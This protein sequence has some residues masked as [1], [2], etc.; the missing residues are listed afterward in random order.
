MKSTETRYCRA[1]EI[2]DQLA[3]ALDA[4]RLARQIDRPIDQATREFEFLSRANVSHGQFLDIV[5]RFLRH[6]LAR[7]FPNG[8]QLS[9]SQARDEAV[10]VL[11][12]A[13]SSGGNYEAFLEAAEPSEEGLGNVLVRVA[14]LIKVRQRDAHVRWAVATHIDPGDWRMKCQMAAIL[15]ERCRP[16]LPTE[17][18]NCPPEQ[19]AD[20]VLE[21]LAIDLATRDQRS[22]TATSSDDRTD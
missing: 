19:M 4:E 9:M 21:L 22:Q 1:L 20:H 12:H 7:A 17:V 5:A 18:R 15:L 14:D 10:A 8:R 2:L 11:E 13:A 3:A 6:L 16:W